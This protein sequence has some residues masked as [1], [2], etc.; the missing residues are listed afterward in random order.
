MN[1]KASCAWSAFVETVKNF[2]G[3]RKAVYYKGIVAKL[4]STLQGYGC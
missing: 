2:L 1:E 3:N 4:L